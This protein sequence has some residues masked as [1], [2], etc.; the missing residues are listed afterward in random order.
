MLSYSLDSP[1]CKRYEG[2]DRAHRNPL[3]LHILS[4]MDQFTSPTWSHL[5][6]SPD[7][8]LYVAFASSMRND[9]TYL[10]SLDLVT[11]TNI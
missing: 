5:Y 6:M 8:M 9:L 7:K 3:R 2:T 4:H 1:L 10:T 11:T